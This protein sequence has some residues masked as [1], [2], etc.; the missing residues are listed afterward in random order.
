MGVANVPGATEFPPIN[1]VNEACP[2]AGDTVW[3]TACG[4]INTP[5]RPMTTSLHDS[6]FSEPT[7]KD[8]ALDAILE[9]IQG[10]TSST[11]KE[12]HAGE[13]VRVAA[14][15]RP[16]EPFVPV[17]PDSFARGPTDRQRSR[18]PDAE[19]PP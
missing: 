16:Q 18:G 3:P 10:R 1:G 9:R 19:V 15:A 8:A 4:A 6:L 14:V 7:E 12:F 13:S 17:E 11:G 5:N 2:P